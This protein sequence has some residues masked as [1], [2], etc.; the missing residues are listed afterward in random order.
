MPTMS[1]IDAGYFSENNIKAL[2]EGNVSFLTR[3][4][5]GRTIYKSLVNENAEKIELKEN[6][7]V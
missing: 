7:V 2:Y 5:S 3:M 4:P 6:T 1:I